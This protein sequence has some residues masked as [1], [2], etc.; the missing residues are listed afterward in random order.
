MKILQARASDFSNK[1]SIC[2]I[3]EES[4][5]NIDPFK[6]IIPFLRESRIFKKA[7]HYAVRIKDENN[8]DVDLPEKITVGEIRRVL[9]LQDKDED[10]IIGFI[11][12]KGYTK[13]MFCRPYKFLVHCMIHAL[14]HRKG[15]YDE[16]SDYIRNII[17]SLV[18]NQ[19]YNIYQVIFIT[20]WKT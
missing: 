9:D 3:L 4:F 10:P 13:S 17:V 6:D 14:A 8:K 11:N 1:H 16:A 5:P 2:C 12:D 15:A 20:C 7:I 19:P 18:L